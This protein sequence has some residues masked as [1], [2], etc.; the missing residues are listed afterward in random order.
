MIT[1]KARRKSS[2]YYIVLRNLIVY[3]SVYHVSIALIVTE[4]QAS[5]RVCCIYLHGLYRK[6]V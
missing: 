1:L 3:I 6:L 5:S 4:A 2:Y